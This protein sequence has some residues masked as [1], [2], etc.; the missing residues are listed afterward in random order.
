MG[1]ARGIYTFS[2]LGYFLLRVEKIDW[3]SEKE[4]KTTLSCGYWVKSFYFYAK[5][6][7]MLFDWVLFP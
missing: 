4:A 1:F 7:F 3:H 6:Y 2:I 5:N